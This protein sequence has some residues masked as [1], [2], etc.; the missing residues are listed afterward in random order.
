MH[1]DGLWAWMRGCAKEHSHASVSADVIEGVGA[2]G[3]VVGLT[4]GLL[5][6]LSEFNM[7][8]VSRSQIQDLFPDD[9]FSP[10]SMEVMEDD[11]DPVLANE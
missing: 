4:F 10:C 3:W 11:I 9:C 2:C 6:L 1:V 7:H 5:G 8:P